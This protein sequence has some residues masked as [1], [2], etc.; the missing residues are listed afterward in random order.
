M[1]S[2]TSS[3]EG[4]NFGQCSGL[5]LL[6]KDNSLRLLYIIN[7]NV[8]ISICW[9]VVFQMPIEFFI[10]ILLFLSVISLRKW[11]SPVKMYYYAIST[12]NMITL[13]MDYFFF[14][15]YSLFYINIF[16]FNNNQIIRN[17]I[18][19]I[20]APSNKFEILCRLMNMLSDIG[21]NSE[22][23]ATAIFAIHRMFVVLYP[24]NTRRIH[25]VFN[26][27]TLIL[28]LLLLWILSIPNFFLANYYQNNCNIGTVSPSEF[29]S[30]FAFFKLTYNYGGVLA[31]IILSVT[32]IIFKLSK[33]LIFRKSFVNLDVFRKNVAERRSTI[34]LITIS[35][36]YLVINGPFAIL[37]I[38]VI[39][40]STDDS[41]C[42]I[43]WY[44]ICQELIYSFYFLQ[45]IFRIADGI[46]F[47]TMVPEIRRAACNLLHC[48]FNTNAMHR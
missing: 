26:K 38:I 47:F 27:W 48:R 18:Y 40:I 22:F 13:F 12:V 36:I 30:I 31:L 19:A 3:S 46:I 33:D 4:L 32:V 25:K 29:W 42:F 6:L 41:N 24:L 9:I 7:L 15:D 37:Q 10:V 34:V 17:I 16:S 2:S 43:L 23:W 35:M 21:C 45:V 28:F 14:F 11:H 8:F 39:F 5:Q 44:Y 20:R 1:N